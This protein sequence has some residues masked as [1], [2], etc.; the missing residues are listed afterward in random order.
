VFKDH[1]ST[2]ARDYGR[3]RPGYPDALIAFVASVAPA[4]GLALDVATGSGQAA[5]M[6]A[7]YFQS[8]LASDA[9]AEQL[10][11]AK[12]HPRVHYLRH[13]AEQLPVRAGVVDA[14]AVAQA[15]H[16][17]DLDSFYE[18]ARRVLRPRGVVALWTYSGIELGAPLDEPIQRFYT[19]TVGQYWPPE[20]VHV[21]QQYRTLPFPLTELKAPP[22]AYTAE[23]SLDDLL[24]YVSTWSAVA[25][26]RR[27]RGSDPLPALGAALQHLWPGAE[28]RPVHF[29]LHLRIGRI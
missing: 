26:Y 1:F 8:V 14:I 22:F 7:E 15:A 9:S 20:R 16:W 21:E 5:L 27:A 12:A 23:W 28:R 10:R 24:G 17:F 19:D 11:Q 6:L 29:P 3:Y 4:R 2:Q 13:R 25:G 18:E